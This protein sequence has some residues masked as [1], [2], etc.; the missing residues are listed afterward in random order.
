MK[1]ANI[2]PL[3]EMGSAN[4]AGFE[5]GESQGLAGSSN[6]ANERRVPALREEE[7]PEED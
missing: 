7:M 5:Q 2:K 4:F 3:N 6:V 1:L